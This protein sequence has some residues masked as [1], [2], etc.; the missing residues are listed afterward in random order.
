MRVRG[1]VAVVTGGAGSIGKAISLELSAEG[2]T[3]WV[4]DIDEERSKSIVEEL[5]MHGRRAHSIAADFTSSDQAESAVRQVVRT[6]GQI[7]ILVNNAGG[8]VGLLFEDA[9]ED[10]FRRNIDLNLKSAFFATK[11]ACPSMRERH[12]GSIVFISSVNVLLGGL[13]QV[14]YA[15]AKAG[16]HSLVRSLTAEYSSFGLRFNALCVGSV[17]GESPVWKEREQMYPGTI[18]QVARLYPLR[19]VGEPTDVAKAVLFLASDESSWITG[20][21]VPVDGG[22][23]A[24]GGLPGGRWWTSLSLDPDSTSAENDTNA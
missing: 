15:A 5:R 4:V 12:R 1:K 14:A 19:R 20:S 17:P 18:A 8:S 24:T 3:V 16:I 23:S 11:A 21:V 9:D 2:A 7:D 6:E 13:G 22:I 10:T